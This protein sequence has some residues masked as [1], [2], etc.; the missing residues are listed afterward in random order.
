[1]SGLDTGG[2][3]VVAGIWPLESLR[4]AEFL[5]NEVPGVFV[6][7]GVIDRMRIAQEQGPDFAAEEGLA[8]AREAV[9]AVRE[10]AQG[11]HIVAPGGRIDPALTL[12]ET[13]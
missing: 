1:L 11:V 9:N 5:Q 12:L 10:Q 2:L 3:P 13:L 6:P 4:Q 8:I 7:D